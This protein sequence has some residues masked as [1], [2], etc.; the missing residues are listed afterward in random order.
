MKAKVELHRG[1]PERLISYVLIGA[2]YNLALRRK[3]PFI[4]YLFR[5]KKDMEGPNNLD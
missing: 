1:K 3:S 4:W 2:R 5:M